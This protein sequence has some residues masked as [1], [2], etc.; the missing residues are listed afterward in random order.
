MG[1]SR[2]K[3]YETEFPYFM[4]STVV[5]WQPVFIVPDV[6]EIIFDS[7]KYLQTE[8]KVKI[9]GYVIMENHLHLI[10][11]SQDLSRH[12]Q[13][14]KSFTAKSILAYLQRRGSRSLL[15][16][17]QFH[18]KKHKTESVHQ[19]WEEKRGCMLSKLTRTKSCYNDWST[20]T[21][22][23]SNVDMWMIQPTGAIQVRVITRGSEVFWML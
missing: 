2:F 20:C 21:T 10:A 18:K 8:K 14:F 17:F 16:E 11:Q 22:F 5:D 12:L 7:L 19:F 15:K 1:R 4:T 6:V 13:Q 23:R 9:L 3:I